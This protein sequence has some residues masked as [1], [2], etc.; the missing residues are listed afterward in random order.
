MRAGRCRMTHLRWRRGRRSRARGI[1][2]S[3]RSAALALCTAAA[4][5]CTRPPPAPPALPAAL[6]LAPSATALAAADWPG[7]NRDL[8]GT[9]FSPLAQINAGN[10]ANLK[11]AWGY[12][13]GRNT[14]TGS[15][16]GGSELTPLAVAGVLYLATADRIVALDAAYGAEIWSHAR[17]NT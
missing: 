16:R 5:G 11:R 9:R 13:L 17:S 14:T 4:L 10:V 8:A 6:R 3:V 2:R 15:L 1:G 7:Y 12:D